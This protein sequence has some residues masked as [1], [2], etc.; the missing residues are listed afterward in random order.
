MVFQRVY[1]PLHEKLL[2]VYIS[3]TTSIKAK[4]LT[5]QVIDVKFSELSW[6][7]CTFFLMVECNVRA[8]VLVGS[9]RRADGD[10]HVG[11]PW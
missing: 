4:G 2:K 6:V 11:L 9:H 1:Q 8:H 3:P 10:S 5:G 7:S